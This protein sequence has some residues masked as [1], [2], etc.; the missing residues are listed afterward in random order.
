MTRTLR[1]MFRVLK[2]GKAAIVVV[3]N[4]IMRGKDTETQNCL[5]DIGKAIGFEI[6]K[7][8]TR[9]LDRNKRMLP[10]GETIN[11]D[12]QIQKRMHEEYVIGFIKPES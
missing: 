9:K 7:I 8:G 1:E 5:S 2:P 4:S 6:P 11:K 12:S 10:A 3:G